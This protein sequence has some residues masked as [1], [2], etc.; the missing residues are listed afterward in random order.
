MPGHRG[1][2]RRGRGHTPREWLVSIGAGARPPGPE[3]LAV[4]RPERLFLCAGC[5]GPGL[6]SFWVLRK[7][8]S[9]SP[10]IVAV[11]AGGLIGGT[12]AAVTEPSR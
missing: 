6:L 3:H 9:V 4:G 2:V 5:A 8:R 1:G 7:P 10:T 11:G 12:T